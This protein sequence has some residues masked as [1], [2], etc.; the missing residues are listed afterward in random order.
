MSISFSSDNGQPFL[1]LGQ[2]EK[3]VLLLLS[4]GRSDQEIAKALFLGEGTICN[5]INSI[6]TKLGLPDKAEATAYALKHN[7]RGHMGHTD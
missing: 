2:Q 6:L 4:N 7:L 3:Q 5:Y 1:R